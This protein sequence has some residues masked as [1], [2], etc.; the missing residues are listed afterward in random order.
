MKSKVNIPAV[1]LLALACVLA[2][3]PASAGVLY[4]NT[5]PGS[6]T[7]NAWSFYNGGGGGSSVTDSFT[8]ASGLDHVTG[9]DFDVWV[10]PGDSLNSYTWSIS[11]S[12][13]GAPIASGNVAGGPNTQVATAYG[14]Y[15]ILQESVSIP[16]LDLTAGTYW[17]ELSNGSDAYD[18]AVW[19]D[20]SD[21]ASAAFSSD[22][23]AIASETFQ[24]DGTVPEPSSVLLLAPAMLA[25]AGLTRKK[26]LA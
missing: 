5:G 2:A 21:G 9:I 25:L 22:A 10:N 8:V 20:E 18:T 13:F 17:L 14:Y 19:W 7:T 15:S 23:G 12:A 6:L 26:L 4:D 11:S 3:V 16:D 1:F 24:I